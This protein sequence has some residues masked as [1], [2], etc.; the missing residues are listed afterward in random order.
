VF[1]D[2]WS[3]DGLAA[4]AC[5]QEHDSLRACQLCADFAW[6]YDIRVLLSANI[7]AEGLGDRDSVAKRAGIQDSS[8]RYTPP[9]RKLLVRGKREGTTPFIIQFELL[10]RHTVK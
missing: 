2:W 7:P 1:T 6:G 3:A 8:S 10:Y 9:Y 5:S 4:G